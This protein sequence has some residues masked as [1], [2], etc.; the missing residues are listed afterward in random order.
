MYV[1]FP[2]PTSSLKHV[3]A[4]LFTVHG[5]TSILSQFTY[6]SGG[7]K[8]PMVYKVTTIQCVTL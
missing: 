2:P 5:N 1:I 4:L 3:C 7:S 6:Q 8:N